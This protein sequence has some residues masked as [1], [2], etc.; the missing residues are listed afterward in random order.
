MLECKNSDQLRTKTITKTKTKINFERKRNGE[1]SLLIK[2]HRLQSVSPINYV[3]NAKEFYKHHFTF[4]D[5]PLGLTEYSNFVTEEF[6][7]PVT[8]DFEYI[9]SANIAERMMNASN[10]DGIMYPS[11]RT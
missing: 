10:L 1:A 9:I 7:K 11:V 4:I 3:K 5:A 8:D 6:S 2:T